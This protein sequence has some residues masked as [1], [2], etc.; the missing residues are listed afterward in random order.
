MFSKRQT[1][2][3][4]VGSFTIA[5]LLCVLVFSAQWLTAQSIVSGD[6]SGTVTDSSGAIVPNA[7]VSLKSNDTGATQSTTTNQSGFYRFSL[8]KPGN[9][10]ITI[11][12]QGF[13]TVNQPAVVTTGQQT[14]ANFKLP[15][16]ATTETVE[17]TGQAPLLQTENGNLS[18]NFNARDIE[19]LPNGGG[20]TTYIAQTAPGVKI[21]TTGSGGYGNFSAYGLPA[22]SNL[23]TVNGNDNMDP[24]LNL[25]N[26]GAT[27][28]SL[29]ANELQEATVV[30]NGYSG[31]FGRQAGAQ[32]NYTTK[33][34]TNQYH[35]NAQYW[36]NG[37]TLNAN[38]WFNNNQGADRPFV[39]ANQ[40]ATSFG[41]PIK[42]DKTFFFVDYEG[43]RVVLPTSAQTIIPSQAFQNYVLNTAL[44]A[45]G[46]AASIP[47]YQSMFNLFN[48]A[49]GAASATPFAGACE[50]VVLPGGA[51]C[52]RE[53]RSTAGNFTHEWILAARVDQVLGSKDRLFG[54]FRTD[55]GVQ[56]SYTDPISP[57]FNATS[58]QPQY[59]GQLNH[60]HTFGANAVNQFIMSGSYY[61]AFFNNDDRAASLAAFPTTIFFNNFNSL[62]G[63]NNSWPQGRNT[64]QYQ[65]VDDFSLTKGAHTLKFGANYRRNNVTDGS[66]GV[67]TSGR[68]FVT[69]LSSFAN[70]NVDIFQQRFPTRTTQPISLYSVGVYAQDQWRIT[71][72]FNVDLSLR[73]DHASNPVCQ[74]DC[75]SRLAAPWEQLTHDPNLPYNQA[76]L[77]GQHQAFANTDTL[78]W[79]PR[80][81][82][83]WQ[84]FGDEKTVIRGGAGIFYDL[85]PGNIVGFFARNSPNLNQF[86]FGGPISPA[87]AGNVFNSVNAF[88]DLF[89]T[90]F[91]NGATL[92]SLQA[93]IPTFRPPDFAS[94]ESTF[95]S[96]QFQEWNL[97]I[98]RALTD[99]MSFSANYV[100]NHGIH[101]PLFNV[102]NAFD[103]TA[104]NT[105]LPS[106]APDARFSNVTQL[107]SA[108]VSNYNGM[109][110]S[111][112]RRFSRL[113]TSINYTWSHAID[114][115]SNGGINPFN[116][117][118]SI[119]LQIDPTNLRRLN[120]SDADYDVRHYL[121]ANYVWDTGFSFSNG[122]LN[123]TLGGWV[124]SGTIFTRTAT[125][126]S[127]INT[128]LN[129]TYGNFAQGF[130]VF[131]GT[132]LG[133]P[134]DRC[135][136]PS[137]PCLQAS[138]FDLNPNPTNFGNIR[139]NMFR[140]P[141]YFN[142]DL[143][144]TKNFK[145]TEAM[146]LGVGANFYNLLNH[147]NFANPSLPANGTPMDIGAV[148]T[149]QFGA[150]QQTLSPPTSPIGAFLAGDASYRMIQLN[151]KITF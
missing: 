125:P 19:L 45:A 131:T 118:E 29:G 83:A 134:T 34:G 136:S 67:R 64:A 3:R 43:L 84:P 38:S 85:A 62:G 8:L 135:T 106:V 14:A 139:R 32:V 33:A 26:S 116:L 141:G 69:T 151:A 121:S 75:F 63:I 4:S 58:T 130:G 119:Q 27:N 47:F 150:I 12:Q 82:F 110:V 113:Q 111:F 65:F 13:Q 92:A 9:Y 73:V 145:L 16:G 93:S 133:G 94:Q 44:P 89:Q 137:A 142:T 126:Y 128:G 88:N 40:W 100:G 90:Q 60:T 117:N 24:Y 108:G 42:K 15:V 68:A 144:V 59:E 115:V 55:H 11:S 123:Q 129:S 28:L 72:R 31:Q 6:I 107:K 57:L 114:E 2:N 120:Y 98:Q 148:G 101:I 104:T 46:N 1:E 22:T 127:V 49:P 66:F 10:T 112:Q 50:D 78:L 132:F 61:S 51:E 23:Y 80:I 30:N 122:I 76:I 97:E 54:R 77:T 146:R 99:K 17:V 149:P 74:T 71:P 91:A 96:P 36:W 21:N 86:T 124:V 20:D 102:M 35:G 70:G 87:Q 81:G 48:N 103:P 53:F 109:T 105:Q 5:L 41:G 140:G 39:N 7:K 25:N 56:A 37:R 18:T 138:Q 143:S 52:A 79:Q 95:K 147:P